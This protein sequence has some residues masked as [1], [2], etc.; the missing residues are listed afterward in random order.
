MTASDWQTYITV[1]NLVFGVINSRSAKS[2]VTQ[3]GKDIEW[4]NTKAI[5]ACKSLFEDNEEEEKEE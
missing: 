5:S 4:V 2:A 1:A 3:L